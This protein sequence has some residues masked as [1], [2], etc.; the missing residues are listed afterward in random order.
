[1]YGDPKIKDTED[2]SAREIVRAYTYHQ[3]VCMHGSFSAFSV[4]QH[5]PFHATLKALS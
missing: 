3:V 1:M 5:H 2:Y 4:Q